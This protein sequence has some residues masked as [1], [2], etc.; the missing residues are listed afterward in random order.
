MDDEYDYD[1]PGGE[2]DTD[3]DALF[4]PESD[5]D[6]QHEPKEEE[7]KFEFIPAELNDKGDESAAARKRTRA[8]PPEPPTRRKR[9]KKTG[10]KIPEKLK[11]IV[12]QLKE[13]KNVGNRIVKY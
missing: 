1:N 10:P 7:P 11:R 3:E 9:R 5:D 6:I 13:W 12:K 2:Y 8:P 4:G